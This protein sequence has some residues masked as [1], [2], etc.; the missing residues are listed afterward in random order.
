ME[1]ELSEHLG[2]AKHAMEQKRTA[3]ARN[4]RTTKRIK[5]GTAEVEIAVPR[6]RDG[7]FEPQ[8]VPK[9]QRCLAGFDEKVLARRM[10]AA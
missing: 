9:R 5:T 8:L 1:A 10:R 6:D 4:G 7:S 2:Y 3:N